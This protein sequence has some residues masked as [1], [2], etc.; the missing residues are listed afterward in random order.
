LRR[1]STQPR[2]RF[3][4]A[5]PAKPTTSRSYARSSASVGDKGLDDISLADVDKLVE[6][7]EAR[8][9]SGAT[10]NRHLSA[11]NKFLKWTLSREYRV[12][13]L[14]KLEWEAES[15]GRIRWIEPDEEARLMELL[16]PDAAKLVRCAILTG[17]RRGELLG[18]KPEQIEWHFADQ[19]GWVRLWDTKNKKPRSVPITHD[20]YEDLRYLADGRMPRPDD[21][22]RTWNKARKTMRL[23]K[24]PWFVF[25][26][27]R[28]TCATRLVQ[29]NVNL[30]VVKEFMGHKTIETTL[31][32]AHVNAT[33]LTDALKT[34]VAHSGRRLRKV[35]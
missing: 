4:K 28:H 17:M 22:G 33:S 32:Y 10:I 18:L 12:R 21:L 25:H 35:A 9:R 19:V 27:C 8:G 14:F 20:T 1:L 11:L 13:P 2:A 15:E 31:R 24:D 23:S 3:G 6:D 30:A 7:L 29:A 34:L 5:S 26:C 16:P